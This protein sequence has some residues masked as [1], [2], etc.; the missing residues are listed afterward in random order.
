MTHFQLLLITNLIVS[1]LY[2]VPRGLV[3]F[4]LDLVSLLASEAAVID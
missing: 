3:E 2:A 4:V 1:Q